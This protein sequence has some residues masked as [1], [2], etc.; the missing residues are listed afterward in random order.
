MDEEDGFASGRVLTPARVTAVEAVLED[1]RTVRG[2]VDRG[3]WVLLGQG[4]GQMRELRAIGADGQVLQRI[5]LE[6]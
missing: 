2:G 4:G 5:A 1:G 3:V 6:S